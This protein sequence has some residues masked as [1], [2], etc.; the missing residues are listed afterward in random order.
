MRWGAKKAIA[1]KIIERGGH[2]ALTVKENQPKLLED[3]KDAVLH[4]LESDFQGIQTR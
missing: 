3:I 2:F 4:A 1:S